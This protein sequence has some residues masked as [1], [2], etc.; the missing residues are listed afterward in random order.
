LLTATETSPQHHP[1]AG[2]AS[3]AILARRRRA[4]LDAHE[5]ESLKR[6]DR[7]LFSKDYLR[8]R[9]TGELG[10]EIG[11]MSSATLFDQRVRRWNPA[12]LDR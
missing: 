5:P 2:F 4:W 10:L 9:L 7:A 6:A 11:D 1:L 8:F 12:A 3:A